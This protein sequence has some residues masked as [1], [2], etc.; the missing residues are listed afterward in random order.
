MTDERHRK[1]I[2]M[3]PYTHRHTYTHTHTHTNTHTHTP[4]TKTHTH[5]HTKKSNTLI[6]LIFPNHN[7]LTISILLVRHDRKLSTL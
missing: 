3:N 5:T 6:L 2:V 1:I 7:V 4:H